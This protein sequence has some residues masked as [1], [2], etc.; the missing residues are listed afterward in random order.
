[1]THF[2][3]DLLMVGGTV[4]MGIGMFVAGFADLVMIAFGMSVAGSVWV[5]LA[6]FR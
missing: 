4:L 3:A 5:I 1:M 2:F 6:R